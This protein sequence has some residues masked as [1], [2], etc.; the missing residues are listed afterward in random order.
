[1][2][3]S[4]H[5]SQ[6]PDLCEEEG[7]LQSILHIRWKDATKSPPIVGLHPAEDVVAVH[8]L[9]AVVAA[10]VVGGGAAGD[11]GGDGRE[12]GADQVRNY[13]ND[14]HAG[15]VCCGLDTSLATLYY[16]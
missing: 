1:M 8:G 12:D 6:Y 9:G 2:I 4:L 3:C 5:P 13:E 11:L 14:P 15:S 10:L 16:C 7:S